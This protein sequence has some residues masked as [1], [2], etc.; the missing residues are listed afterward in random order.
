MHVD[1]AGPHPGSAAAFEDDTAAAGP[2]RPGVEQALAPPSSDEEENEPRLKLQRHRD[3]ARP[4]RGLVLLSSSDDD[5]FEEAGPP[6]GSRFAATAAPSESQLAAELADADP[7]PS[8]GAHLQTLGWHAREPPPLV[9]ILAE[10]WR[11]GPGGPQGARAGASS[12][13]HRRKSWESNVDA[14]HFGR[15]K[16]QSR[17]HG[18]VFEQQSGFSYELPPGAIDFKARE[19]FSTMLS[20]DGGETHSDLRA[21]ARDRQSWQD[22]S[23]HSAWPSGAP[24]EGAGDEMD[25]DDGG[26]EAGCEAGGGADFGAGFE[27]EE[28][29]TS[30]LS[31]DDSPSRRA[32]P[33]SD[34]PRTQPR[35]EQRQ[36]GRAALR[37]DPHRRLSVPQLG[38]LVARRAGGGGGVRLAAVAGAAATPGG[39]PSMSRLFMGALWAA[40]TQHVLS[41]QSRDGAD[42]T[43]PPQ[44][45]LPFAAGKKVRLVAGVRDQ[46]GRC[47]DVQVQLA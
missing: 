9:E 24:C 16:R 7:A 15:D 3:K 38:Q 20:M 30:G 6:R 39:A 37:A 8:G 33:P 46:D 29:D 41:L 12:R 25:A 26:S 17:V 5:D 31:L 40:T 14:P 18:L 23:R 11:D 22:N 43:V 32:E 1:E 2:S 47:V 34:E 35:P 44:V 28:A 21:R 42:R 19:S 4:R 27:G 45:G 13:S 36:L 10:H